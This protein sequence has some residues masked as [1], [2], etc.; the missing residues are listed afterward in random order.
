MPYAPR[1]PSSA[2]ASRGNAWLRSHSAANGASRSRAKLRIVSRISRCDSES[3][4]CHP[5]AIALAP[6]SGRVAQFADQRA[7]GIFEDAA[8]RRSHLA[9]P[10]V[11]P[12]RIGGAGEVGVNPSSLFARDHWTACMQASLQALD[13]RRTL[14]PV[15]EH[16]R[17]PGQRK[18]FAQA[19]EL[20][21]RMEYQFL[22]PDFD[23]ASHEL[24]RTATGFHIVSPHFAQHAQVLAGSE[25]GLAPG[26][27]G[28]ARIADQMNEVRLRQEGCDLRHHE[29][30]ARRFLAVTRFAF[31]LGVHG[32]KG[33]QPG[34]DGKRIDRLEPAPQQ[35]LVESE[36][37]PVGKDRKSTRLNSSHLV[38]S[39]AV[40][41]LKKKTNNLSF[42]RNYCALVV[43]QAYAPN[44]IN[45]PADNVVVANIIA[46]L[47]TGSA[48]EDRR[49][50]GSG[51][52]SL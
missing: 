1:W 6:A 11:E 49:V 48:L 35:I 5:P 30:V 20:A 19:L 16:D 12:G 39:Y 13:A 15:V 43:R 46:V 44:I 51:I 28:V 26:E 31:A 45:V 40:F 7:R 10:H 3:S 38:I 34:G 22:E 42:A 52:K 17:I 18:V 14:G 25:P 36:I 24:R 41:C 9:P 23:I 8:F 32:V 37:R 2:S 4:I 33:A 27:H 21:L 29:H 47:T 50:P